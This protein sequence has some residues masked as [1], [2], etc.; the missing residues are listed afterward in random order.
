MGFGKVWRVVLT[1]R[2][3]LEIESEAT[4]ETKPMKALRPSFASGVSGTGILS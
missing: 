4:D 2:S 1:T 3:E